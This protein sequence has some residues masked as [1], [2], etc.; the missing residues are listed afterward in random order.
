MLGNQPAEVPGESV[1]CSARVNQYSA[2]PGESTTRREQQCHAVG[3]KEYQVEEQQCMIVSLEE[4]QPSYRN[5]R[6]MQTVSQEELPGESTPLP[7]KQCQ[8]VSQ[9]ECQVQEQQCQLVSLE[10]GQPSHRSSRV[11]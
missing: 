2:V 6:A 10:E 1:L 3:R 8:T 9:N 11:R 7:E 5:S 4:G